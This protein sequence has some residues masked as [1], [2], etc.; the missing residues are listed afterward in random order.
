MAGFRKSTV[1]YPTRHLECQIYFLF[2]RL[3]DFIGNKPKVVEVSSE[4]EVQK[5]ATEDIIL[6]VED[7]GKRTE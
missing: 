7:L 3:V 6:W 2:D 4:E 5:V 1:S